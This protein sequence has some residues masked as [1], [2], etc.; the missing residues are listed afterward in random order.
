MQ[1]TYLQDVWASKLL[2]SPRLFGLTIEFSLP[3]HQAPA[4]EIMFYLDIG[5]CILGTSYADR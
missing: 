2:S 5:Q 3:I 1:T 4:V